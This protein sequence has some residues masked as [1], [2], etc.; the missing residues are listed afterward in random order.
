MSRS[1]P[2]HSIVS[3]R[4]RRFLQLGAA[5]S[6]AL[7]ACRPSS[8]LSSDQPSFLGGP[9]S[10]YGTRSSLERVTRTFRSS[11]SRE[12]ASSRTPLHAYLG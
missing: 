8:N 7:V 6:S 11:L 3:R 2:K 5:L 9:V 1:N 4:R 10:E 12:N